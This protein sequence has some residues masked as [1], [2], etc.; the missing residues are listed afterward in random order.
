MWQTKSGLTFSGELYATV[1]GEPVLRHRE[2]G[3]TFFSPGDLVCDGGC[4]GQPTISIPIPP[5]PIAFA[6]GRRL[7]TPDRRVLVPGVDFRSGGAGG[8]KP[9]GC[10]KCGN[11]GGL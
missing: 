8:G 10:N 9:R 7:V 11:D 6:D 2:W 1:S 5:S 3:Q 4:G